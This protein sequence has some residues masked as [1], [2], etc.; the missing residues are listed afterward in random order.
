MIKTGLCPLQDRREGFCCVKLYG[1]IVNEIPLKHCSNL[2]LITMV[3][4]M[5]VRPCI[6]LYGHDQHLLETRRWV[7]ER[8]GYDIWTACS[9][10]ALNETISTRKTDILIL[11]HSLSSEECER[12]VEVAHRHLPEIK[13]VVLTANNTDCSAGEADNVLDTAEG[14]Q[15]LVAAVQ[16]LMIGQ[17]SA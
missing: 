1:R 14:P 12:A 17:E 8:S 10:L 9:L 7:L 15:G 6:L 5:L 2:S 16:Q 13:T 11:C 3:A 4:P